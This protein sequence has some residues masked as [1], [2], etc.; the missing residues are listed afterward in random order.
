M[1]ETKMMEMDVEKTASLSWDISVL[2]SSANLQNAKRAVSKSVETEYSRMGSNVIIE[3][4][5]VV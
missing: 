1:T 5:A 2:V 4:R 3:I